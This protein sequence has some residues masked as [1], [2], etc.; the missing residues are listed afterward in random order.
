MNHAVVRE[1]P[2]FYAAFCTFGFE[3]ETVFLDSIVGFGRLVPF[4]PE[5]YCLSFHYLK[6]F[7]AIRTLGLNPAFFSDFY[8][9]DKVSHESSLRFP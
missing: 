2:V 3:T 7:V 8:L 1:L 9:G 4:P 6:R 5:A